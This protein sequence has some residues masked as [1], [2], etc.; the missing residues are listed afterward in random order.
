MDIEALGN[1][2]AKI[3]ALAPGSMAGL[4]ISD[5][6]YTRIAH[7]LF[8]TLPSSFSAAITSVPLEPADFG[9]CVKAISQGKTITCPDVANDRLFDPLWRQVC[10]Q[11]GIG[12]IQSRP[13]YV[14]G[15]PKGTFVLAYRAPKPESEWDATLMAFAADAAGNVLSTV[16]A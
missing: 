15:R 8:P 16:T 7:A 13:F 9:S 6:T 2:C 12:A 14:D 11:H 1:L 3:E 5:D 10:L 4:T